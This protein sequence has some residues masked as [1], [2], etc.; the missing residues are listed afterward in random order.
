MPYQK[1]QG[2][3]IVVRLAVNIAKVCCDWLKCLQQDEITVVLLCH[4]TLKGKQMV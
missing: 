1:Y 4:E 3:P 2:P